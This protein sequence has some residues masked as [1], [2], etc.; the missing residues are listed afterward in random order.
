MSDQ[1]YMLAGP[2]VRCGNLPTI[3]SQVP[4]RISTRW[5]KSDH[6]QLTDQ[7]KDPAHFSCQRGVIDVPWQARWV[8]SSKT[9]SSA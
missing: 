5:E 8:S 9:W 1:I 6:V 7:R 2:H 4:G 3:K